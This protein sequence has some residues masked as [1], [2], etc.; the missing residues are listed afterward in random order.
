MT[1]ATAGK[2]GPWATPVIYAW[3]PLPALYFM[4]RLSTR[5]ARNIL[6]GTGDVAAAIHP[7]ETR[8]L[9]GVQMTGACEVL[10]GRGALRALRRYLRRFPAA[11]GRFPVR[12]VLQET[13]EI[14]FFRFTP[15]AIFLLSEEHYGWGVRHAVPLGSPEAEPDA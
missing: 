7:N 13:S 2:D 5:H 6:S 1:L 11:R 9:R 14:R 8:P 10:G 15:R 12:A 3:E 4:S